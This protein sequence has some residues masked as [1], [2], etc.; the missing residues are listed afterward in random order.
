M[1]HSDR[2][3]EHLHLHEMTQDQY[4]NALTNFPIENM[5]LHCCHDRKLDIGALCYSKKNYNSR[6]SP[7]P[8]DLKT[9]RP[10]RISAFRAWCNV[11]GGQYYEEASEYTL[12]QSGWELA[13]FCI[14]CDEHQRSD[15]LIDPGAFKVALD[16]YTA[17][18]MNSV[19]SNALNSYTANRLQA[20]AIKCGYDIFP[21]AP[22]N[23]HND[24]PIISTA[25]RVQ[26]STRTPSADEMAA[27]LTP[28]QYLF[29]GLTDFL[30]EQKSYPHHIKYMDAYAL[31]LPAG[32]PITTQKMVGRKSKIR[33][34]IF[35]NYSTGTINS[36][37]HCLSISADKY[38]DMEQRREEVIQTL[39]DANSNKYHPKRLWLA[40]MCQDA[41]F[42][43]FVANT[44][45]N[46]SPAR[47]LL[48]SPDYQFVNSEHKGFK[49]VKPRA[50]G[51][52]QSFEIRT[53]FVKH[54]QKFLQLRSYINQNINSAYLFIGF[55][56]YTPTTSPV[57][58]SLITQFNERL[59]RFLDDNLSGLSHRELRK[60][61]PVYLLNNGYSV[62][63]VAAMMQ[64]DGGT[65][66]SYYADAEEKQAVDEISNVLTL[67]ADIFEA[68]YAK[69]SPA[70]QCATSSPLELT[71]A[72]E[73]YQ[74]NCKNFLGCIFCTE[75][76][77]HA[78]HDG[79]RKLLSMR[80]LISAHLTA[81]S[82]I[83]H[84]NKIHGGAL[85]RID[86]I[87]SRLIDLRPDLQDT[88]TL[89][90]MEVDEQFK[91]HPYWERL[92]ERLVTIKVLK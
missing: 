50:G 10:E 49:V 67:A 90:R 12:Y 92:Y 39:S 76:R 3:C 8:V 32:F 36:L 89:I 46:F 61:K 47:N 57:A 64:H 11:N 35:W 26:K 18:L 6:H 54:F 56:H 78:D 42:S 29:D 73:A 40:K 82:D 16:G 48:Y 74:P 21:G 51:M 59:T 71:V 60:Y 13:R 14:W 55:K 7:K 41:F 87:M 20:H 4:H 24:L 70:G 38:H 81:C 75:F 63:V 53:T 28:C 83:D 68:H 62:P 80:H 45:L 31:L 5:M 79:I 34:G 23:F 44:G 30:L 58:G 15:F 72:P 1:N 22:I 69:N 85:D 77:L 25:N 86:H 2:I 9:L 52:S 91:L 27:Y 88:L 43:L 37:E 33:S 66:I 84:F 17:Y 19:A 65:T